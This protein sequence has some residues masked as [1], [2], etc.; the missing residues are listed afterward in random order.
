MTKKSITR[1]G[2]ERKFVVDEVSLLQIKA[3]RQQ[4]QLT[5]AKQRAAILHAQGIIGAAEAEYQA[6]LA[7]AMVSVGL[8]ADVRAAV[9]LECGLV[10]PGEVNEQGHPT[11]PCP[12]C[13]EAANEEAKPEEPKVEEPK[14]E[15][16]DASQEAPQASEQPEG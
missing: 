4:A 12:V 10:R 6:Q 8:Q 5:A 7:Q 11:S 16:A 3:A 15:E 1:L 9:C 2:K 14:K 13:A